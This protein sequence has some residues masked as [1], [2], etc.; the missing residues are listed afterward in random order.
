MTDNRVAFPLAVAIIALLSVP[1]AAQEVVHVG[2]NIRAPRQ[3]KHVDPV[4]PEE[5]KAA[6]VQGVVVIEIRIGTK[7]SVVEARVLR[8][9]PMLDQAALDAVYQWEYEPTLLNGKPVDV[10]ITVTVNFTLK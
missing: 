9:I 10:E 4:Y 5:A 2:G 7:G 3:V 1:I 8:S 6:G